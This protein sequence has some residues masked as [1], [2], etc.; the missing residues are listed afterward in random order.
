MC[1][2]S[3]IMLLA[4]LLAIFAPAQ[5]DGPSAV[6]AYF[7]S[8]DKAGI[9]IEGVAP[10]TTVATP[11]L[12]KGIY[13]FNAGSPT[14]A[15]VGYVNEAGTL[16]GDAHGFSL[17]IPHNAPRPLSDYETDQLR[18]EVVRNIDVDQL[19]AVR[20]GD[21]G[22]RRLV[23]FSAVDC[24][25]CAK[26][27]AGMAKLAKQAN[28]TFYVVP[29]ALRP[30][31]FGGAAVASWQT[32]GRIWCAP[33]RGAAWLAYWAKRTVPAG[34]DCGGA[35][36]VER[37]A[38]ELSEI[39]EAVGIKPKGTPAVLQENG[40]VFIPR[41]VLDAAYVRETFGAAGMP[42]DD[43]RAVVWL[44]PAAEPAKP[45]DATLPGL[46]KGLFRGH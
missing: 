1:I 24:P 13:R 44:G 5:A 31:S 16:I 27:E 42:P 41:A 11:T 21:G 30:T 14:G 17:I 15:F 18:A 2:S 45:K 25:Y 6:A 8:L 37:R 23:M 12:V 20:Y 10:A 33:D 32:A 28:T 22:G 36:M 7:A 29:S 3:R 26:F 39:L 38:D 34:D 19:V 35:A 40:K 43:G 9:R 4:T 46:L